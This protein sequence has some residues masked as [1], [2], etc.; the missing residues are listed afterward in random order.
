[1]DIFARPYAYFYQRFDDFFRDMLPPIHVYTKNVGKFSR[2]GLALQLGDEYV[3]DA[4]RL[5]AMAGIADSLVGRFMRMPTGHGA[6][7][8][9][10]CHHTGCPLNNMPPLCQSYVAFPP[11]DYRKCKFPEF[12]KW[13][14]LDRFL[15]PDATAR[16]FSGS[17]S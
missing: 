5:A 7:E 16:L 6:S 1:M 3:T 13:L 10:L 8:G 9:Q 15:P 14:G 17:G 2:T 11:D 12:L 4:V